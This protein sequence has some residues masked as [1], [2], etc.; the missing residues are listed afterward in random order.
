MSMRPASSA[1]SI[2]LVNRPLPPASDSGRSWMRSPLV[3][4]TSMAKASSARSCAAISRARVSCACASA[5]G[6][7]RVPILN[8]VVCMA[9]S[10]ITPVE[11]RS[12]RGCPQPPIPGYARPAIME[13]RDKMIRVLGIET[14]CDETAASVVALREGERPEILSNVV[15]SQIEEHAAFG[16]V[17]PEIAAR[18]HVE[19]LDG[20]IEAALADAGTTLADVDAIAATAGPGLIG[21]LIVGLMTGEGD[22]E[23]G[24]QAAAG[25]QPPRRPRADR[26]ADRRPRLSLSAAAR[27]R[28][29][30]PDRAGARRRRLPALG[31]HHRR[32]AGRGLRQDGEDA[33]PALS[34][35]TECRAGGAGTA[36]PTRFA[37]PRPM[38]GAAQPDFSFSGL[39]TAVRQAA[40]AAAPLS[41]Q[42]VADICASF[43]AAVSDALADRV[44][45]SLA[46]FRDRISRYRVAGAGRRR[47]RR[48]QPEDSRGAGGAVRPQRL[49]LRRAAARTLHRQCR[50][51][52]LGGHRAHPRRAIG[53][54]RIRLRAALALAARRSVRAGRRLGPSGSQGMSVRVAV[55]GGG[56]WGTA[57]AM[58]MRRAGHDVRLWAR[59]AAVV[60]AIRQGGNPRYLPGIAIDSGIAGDDRQRRG[61]R[62]RGLR[63]CGHPGAGVA[64]R[65]RNHRQRRAAGRA[66][67]ALRQGHRARHRLAAVAD[68]RRDSARQ[69]G[70]S[71]LRPEF[72]RRRRARAADGSRHRGEGRSAGRPAGAALFDRPFP[73]LFDRRSCRRRDRRRAEERLCD[74]G[75]RRHRRGARRQR[76][77]RHGHARLRRTAAHR[78]R[79]SAPNPKR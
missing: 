11:T 66:V 52:R 76:A 22:R 70:R 40:T 64:L 26:A 47:R 14:S 37:F 63:A 12:N 75:R 43:Q 1:S 7:P 39:K 28:R 65:A 72:C 77:G 2:S 56:A 8:T 25:D 67:G 36:M 38:K 41:D 55:L 73:L 20:I 45:R 50:D 33:R 29:P 71:P 24:R 4:M 17:V 49:P 10:V 51:D 78:R 46:R 54:R 74:R 15:L 62:R 58:Q 61:A 31:D 30:H 6:L 23:R 3:E 32:R 57:L 18:A 48:G 60:A 44:A 16:G 35:R 53:R 21:G 59:D 27:L 19:A 9:R 68:R 34:R 42:D 5:S 69:S 13:R 79:R